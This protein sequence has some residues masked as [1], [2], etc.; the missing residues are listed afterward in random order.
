MFP[1]PKP[2]P[3][4]DKHEL[5]VEMEAKQSTSVSTKKDDEGLRQ[6]NAT[7]PTGI[8]ASNQDLDEDGVMVG[9]RPF[10]H[11]VS[12]VSFFFFLYGSRV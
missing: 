6:G 8:A 5:N 9:G 1:R 7:K 10:W 4:R 12:L 3:K 2:H 11:Q